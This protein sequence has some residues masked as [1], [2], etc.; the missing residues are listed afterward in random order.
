MFLK[1]CADGVIRVSNDLKKP[2][3]DLKAFQDHSKT[4]DLSFLPTFWNDEIVFEDGLTFGGF[5][6]GLEPWKDFL[7]KIFQKD[8]GAYID[9]SR[10]PPD[11]VSDLSY[12]IIKKE[13]S[14]RYETEHVRDD[15]NDDFDIKDFM[16]REIT[17]SGNVAVDHTY[18]FTGYIIGGDTSYSVD[19][20]PV[21]E[22]AS[23]PLYL[24]NHHTTIVDYDYLVKVYAPDKTPLFNHDGFGVKK[25]ENH[26]FI[27]GDYSHTLYNVIE[28]VFKW[29]ARTPVSRDAFVEK[30]N[31]MVIG[32]IDPDSYIPD[33]S[34][35]KQVE[36]ENK[37]FQKVL[38]FAK[39]DNRFK[40]NDFKE[41]VL[42]E[43]RVGH[44]IYKG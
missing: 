41:S 2:L 28:A 6:N 11:K 7:S 31:S 4:D 14:F 33:D 35:S 1:F 21:S 18:S 13:T 34:F 44:N 24:S 42:P 26:S 37:Y 20:S 32:D 30:L 8:I 22:L 17:F 5:L 25:T 12:L 9:E 29:F 38:E 36:S 15:D 19:Y 3:V 27:T 10:L 39:E 40:E 43:V 23:L 16:N